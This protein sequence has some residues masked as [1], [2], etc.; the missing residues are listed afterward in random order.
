M[1]ITVS[2]NNKKIASFNV[3]EKNTVLYELKES[4]ECTNDDWLNSIP[5]EESI[6]FLNNIPFN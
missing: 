6:N 1:K 5:R 3:D 4:K 2:V